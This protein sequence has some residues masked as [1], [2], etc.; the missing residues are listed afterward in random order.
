[1]KACFKK[2]FGAV[3]VLTFAAFI[4]LC[5][6]GLP[7]SKIHSG[8]RS[9]PGVKQLSAC[10]Q[11]GAQHNQNKC[12][13]HNN[14]S[15]ENYKHFEWSGFTVKVLHFSKGTFSVYFNPD[16]FVGHL[17]LVARNNQPPPE[18]IQNLTPVYLQKSILRL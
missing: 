11:P 2:I 1:M 7:D 12:G 18:T 4:L 6:C 3:L 9:S 8:Y 15:L 14:L 16:G 10:C 5:C 13:C 17:I